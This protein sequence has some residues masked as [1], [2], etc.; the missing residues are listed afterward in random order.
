MQRSHVQLC[1]GVYRRA[2]KVNN[3]QIIPYLTV[4][5]LAGL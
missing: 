5:I 1:C 4:L 3:D 2:I